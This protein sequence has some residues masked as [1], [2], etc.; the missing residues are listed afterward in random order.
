MRL[1]LKI[2]REGIKACGKEASKSN[3]GTI[4][5][6][7]EKILLSIRGGCGKWA[8]N[9]NMEQ[10]RDPSCTISIAGKRALRGLPY[11]AGNTSVT[12]E[13]A[14]VVG[15]SDVVFSQDKL[16]DINTRM[17]KSTV[18]EGRGQNGFGKSGSGRQGCNGWH[19]GGRKGVLPE[20]TGKER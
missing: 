15:P 8:T 3:I 2:G 18:P 4:V 1:Y 17:T 20:S 12:V 5:Q 9:V 10:L 6:N 13:R 19:G 7:V 11:Q 16:G 14:G